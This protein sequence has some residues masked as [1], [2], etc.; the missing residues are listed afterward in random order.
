M[1]KKTPNCVKDAAI[2]AAIG[3][4]IIIPGISGGTIALISG[5][6]QRIIR[7]AKSLFSKISK[8]E[9]AIGTS[10]WVIYIQ[11]TPLFVL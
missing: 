9:S 1:K 11:V 2:G 3:T 6:Y 10:T 7:A 5:A 4:A 8:E